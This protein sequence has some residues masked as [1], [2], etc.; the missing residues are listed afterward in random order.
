MLARSPEEAVHFLD[1]A[2]SDGDVDAI[3]G[4]YED[5]AVVV[6]EHGKI[7]RGKAELRSFFQRVASAGSSATQLKTHVL[8]A[9][10]VALFMSRWKLNEKGGD[11]SRTFIATTVFR[12]QPDGSWRALIDNSIGPLI[13]GPD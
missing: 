6:T 13:L 9:D 2:F 1:Q 12:R 10:G 11:V 8:E 5:A 4:F 7:A 3:L